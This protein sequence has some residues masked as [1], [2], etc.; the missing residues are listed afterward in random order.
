MTYKDRFWRKVKDVV[1]K[2]S[3]NSNHQASTINNIRSRKRV[4]KMGHMSLDAAW[5]GHPENRERGGESLL[6]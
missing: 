4:D 1:E 2:L 6:I 5:V 3:F